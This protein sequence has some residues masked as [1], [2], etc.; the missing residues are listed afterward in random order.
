MALRPCAEKCPEPRKRITASLSGKTAF[1][2]AHQTG[3]LAWRVH[4]KLLLVSFG[5]TV[6]NIRTYNHRI[7]AVAVYLR[8]SK[9]MMPPTSSLCGCVRHP[10]TRGRSFPISTGW[11][12][13]REG[14][15]RW[16]VLLREPLT[17]I[18]IIY[19]DDQLVSD[20]VSTATSRGI[21]KEDQPPGPP[22]RSTRLG[23]Q[24]IE[25]R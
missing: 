10:R 13:Q 17:R 4:L 25:V 1:I 14:S 12:K 15:S 18:G 6:C 22:P 24:E 7:W 2:Y 21:Y 16:T 20:S 11:A 3:M 8:G 5:F 19:V 23:L 9:G